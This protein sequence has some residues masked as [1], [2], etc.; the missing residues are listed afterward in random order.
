[1]RV[2]VRVVL[3]RFTL[4]CMGCHRGFVVAY[5]M[6]CRRLVVDGDAKG[7]SPD[8]CSILNCRILKGLQGISLLKSVCKA[9]ACR[10]ELFRRTSLGT[11]CSSFLEYL[12]KTILY[13]PESW[14]MAVPQL[15]SLESQ[16][17]QPISSRAHTPTF[18]TLLHL[19]LLV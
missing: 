16:E 18:W 2:M 19:D 9:D 11:V 10:I 7:G 12:G 8:F 14:N 5:V 13:R 15:Q 1:M 17:N 3:V 4:G 6:S